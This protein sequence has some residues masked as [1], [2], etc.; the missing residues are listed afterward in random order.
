MGVLHK[1]SDHG[2][3]MRY[4]SDWSRW[5]YRRLRRQLELGEDVS[6]SVESAIHMIDYDKHKFVPV[7][8]G[9]LSFSPEG[10]AITGTIHGEEVD[11]RMPVGSVPTL[12]FKPGKYL[13]VQQ[14]RDIY[15]CVLSDGKLVMKFINLVKI[16]YE[17]RQN[18]LAKEKVT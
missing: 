17:L 18:E 14:G 2:P 1:E 10:F 9:K 4:V 13:E 11:I 6:L 5:I 15:R 8:Q 16:F 12:P 7:G 3:E